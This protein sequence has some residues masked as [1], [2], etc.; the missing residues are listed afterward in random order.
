MEFFHRSHLLSEWQ[1]L[2]EYHPRLTQLTVA[3]VEENSWREPFGGDTFLDTGVMEHVATLKLDTW[4]LDEAFREA[5]VTVVFAI[6][7]L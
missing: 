3:E 6:L 1:C 2:V 4:S 7:E 5:Y